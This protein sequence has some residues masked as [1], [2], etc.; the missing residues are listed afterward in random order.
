MKGWGRTPVFPFLACLR[1]IPS[2]IL[3]GYPC[4]LNWLT[5]GVVWPCAGLLA[6][7]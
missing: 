7:W 3:D 6:W 4:R 2:E 5:C 1:L